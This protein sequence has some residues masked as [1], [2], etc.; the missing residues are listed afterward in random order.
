MKSGQLERGGRECFFQAVRW[1]P[2]PRRNLALSIS[3]LIN[4]NADTE[5]RVRSQGHRPR[6]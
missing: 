3:T 4:L 1:R 5:F 2:A 6:P